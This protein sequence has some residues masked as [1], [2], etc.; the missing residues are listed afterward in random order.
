MV[1]PMLGSGWVSLHPMLNY[2]T[3]PPATKIF[4]APLAP[5]SVKGV[6]N[7]DTSRFSASLLILKHLC[8]Q[9]FKLYDG[10]TENLSAVSLRDLPSTT[11]FL[12]TPAS[13]NPTEA[14]DLSCENSLTY[15]ET[16]PTLWNANGNL[17]V[18][19]GDEYNEAA[20]DS[21]DTDPATGMLI[22]ILSPLPGL[23]A[24]SL[25][26][27]VEAELLLSELLSWFDP[28]R[29]FQGKEDDFRNKMLSGYRQS[30][31][32]WEDHSLAPIVDLL[33]DFASLAEHGWSILRG[34]GFLDLILD[35]YVVDFQDPLA[36]ALNFRT[37]SPAKSSIAAS[38]NSV[39]ME[40]LEH[41]HSRIM[42]EQHPLR[43]L[44]PSW[45]MLKFDEHVQ[46]RGSH[47]REMWKRVEGKRIQWRISSMSSEL[48]EEICFRALRSMHKLWTRIDTQQVNLGLRMYV[49]EVP[50]DHARE[51]FIRIIQ[52]LILLSRR[53]RESVPFFEPCSQNCLLKGGCPLELD[54]VIHL[55]HRLTRASEGNESLRQWLAEGEIFRLLDITATRLHSSGALGA[56]GTYDQDD[57]GYPVLPRRTSQGP[58]Y[59]VLVLSMA[60]DLFHESPG[61]IALSNTSISDPD[62]DSSL[63]WI[64][65]H[66]LKP[67]WELELRFSRQHH[68]DWERTLPDDTRLPH[69]KDI[70]SW[71]K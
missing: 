28:I 23:L 65:I 36:L 34:C 18:K 24:L 29:A 10:K 11:L 15:P 62:D 25:W 14:G 52:R 48:D 21:D 47:R 27:V 70:Y 54:G 51:V 7:L 49:Q 22:W 67:L 66:G 55:I 19:P 8:Y 37:N 40:A 5:L 1:K 32:Q 6:M 61:G 4:S 41:T 69:W 53:A 58:R 39:L 35:L 45:P 44:W 16:R 43:G 68:D 3:A 13:D 64:F 42:I 57:M 56:A 2:A 71:I 9:R 30:L 12:L 59:R 63:A 60:W 31:L 26:P 46:K 33:R 50:N 38:C 20:S 17:Y